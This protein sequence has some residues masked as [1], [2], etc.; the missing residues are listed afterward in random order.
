MNW[1]KNPKFSHTFAVIAT[2]VLMAIVGLLREATPVVAGAALATAGASWTCTGCT[3][4]KPPQPPQPAPGT[5]GSA[6]VG[7]ASSTGGAFTTGGAVATGGSSAVV[8]V[9]P[10]CNSV[11]E[12]ALKAANHQRHK[13]GGKPVKPRGAQ[14]IATPPVTGASVFWRSPC[15]A[16]DQGPL[17]SCTGNDAT[18]TSSTPPYKRSCAQA[19]ETA[20]IACYSAATKL[21]N[22][23]A[24][25]ATTCPGSYPPNDTGS[26]ASSAFKAA[27]DLGWFNGTRPV[28]QTL[29]GWH[30]ALL[31]GPCGFDQPWYNAGF[32]PTQCGGVNLTG[33]IA[34]YHSTN[35]AGFDV[36]NQRMWLR[37]SWGDWGVEDGY[38][39]Y[40]FANLR[41]LLAAGATMVCPAV[42]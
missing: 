29:Q 25:N 10:Q 42:S 4:S 38:Y 24:W 33:G 20:A 26:Y 40:T 35:A 32:A 7:G 13:L 34:G 16:L 1:F 36:D 30:D 14:T 31:L 8:V 3:Q 15:T 41:A 5:G 27:T 37:N 21:D 28:I 39:Y 6:S 18:Q 22:G 19:D 9:F 23:C 2:A 17:G 12:H 11:T